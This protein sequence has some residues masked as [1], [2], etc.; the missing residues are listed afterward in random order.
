[1]PENGTLNEEEILKQ[2]ENYCIQLNI[3][4]QPIKLS[5][6]NKYFQTALAKVLQNNTI[7]KA[8]LRSGFRAKQRL[9]NEFEIIGE[10]GKGGFGKVYKC[11]HLLDEKIFAVKK[12][13]IDP[14]GTDLSYA[15]FIFHVKLPLKNKSLVRKKTARL[16][17][18]VKK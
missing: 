3:D 2:L 12:I 17:K 5:Y 14:L 11:R 16:R 7:P 6:D 13:E 10:L 1:M 15:T 9:N 18:C 4:F 8:G